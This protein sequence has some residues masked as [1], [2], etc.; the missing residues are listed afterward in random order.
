MTKKAEQEMEPYYRPG[1]TEPEYRPK[2]TAAAEA[3]VAEAQAEAVEG[4]DETEEAANDTGARKG[5]AK[6]AA[7]KK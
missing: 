5:G 2:G 6:K 1:T 3:T 4:V 7:R